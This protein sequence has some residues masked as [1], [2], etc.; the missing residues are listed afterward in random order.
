MTLRQLSQLGSLRTGAGPNL[1][2]LVRDVE[3]YLHQVVTSQ[4]ELVANISSHTLDSGGKRLR[5]ALVGLCAQAIDDRADLERAIRLGACLEMIH[6]ATLIHDDVIDNAPLRRHRQTA[7]GLYGNAASILSGDVLLSRAM[8]LLAEDGDL[9]VIRAVSKAAVALAE[10]EVRELELRGEF[11]LTEAAYYE[12]LRLKTAAFIECCC[13]V[14][15]MIGQASEAEENA[16]ATYGHHLGMAF[17]LADDTLDFAGDPA[18]TGKAI[19]SDFREGCMTLPIIRVRPLLTSAEL[20]QMKACFGAEPTDEAIAEIRG[21]L[22]EK[23]GIEQA[24]EAA[25][26]EARAAVEALEPIRRSPARDLLADL[27]TFV[28]RR[29]A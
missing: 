4:V 28:V 27:A 26:A 10:G 18:D 9:R 15:G 16:L 24:R 11:D 7:A 17:Q 6:M 8:T 2:A 25:Q 12:T 29:E 21:L 22:E 13:K 3:A 1:Q 20:Q 19:G 23:G 5:P 14:G